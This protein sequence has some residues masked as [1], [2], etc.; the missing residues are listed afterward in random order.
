[1]LNNVPG[2]DHAFNCLRESWTFGD[3]AVSSEK[4][5]C[6]PEATVNT[7]FFGEHVYRDEGVYKLQFVLGNNQVISQPVLVRA[8]RQKLAFSRKPCEHLIP[9]LYIE[10]FRQ[11]LLLSPRPRSEQSTLDFQSPDPSGT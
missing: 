4:R 3:G 10:E 5:N 1:V 9:D 7:E 8:F 11:V 6:A 2:N